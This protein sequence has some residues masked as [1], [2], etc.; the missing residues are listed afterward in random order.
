MALLVA[1]PSLN[2]VKCFLLFRL[3]RRQKAEA[4][5]PLKIFQ[6]SQEAR[7]PHTILVY[8]VRLVPLPCLLFGQV[9]RVLLACPQVMPLLGATTFSITTLGITTQSIMALFAT[10]SIMSAIMLSVAIT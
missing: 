7:Y 3:R 4:F 8:R 10:L 5:V 6:T 1:R 2:V 9:V